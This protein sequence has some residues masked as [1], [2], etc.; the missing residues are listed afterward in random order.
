MPPILSAPLVSFALT[1]GLLLSV[2]W[3]ARHTTGALVAR[4]GWSA[5]PWTTGWLGVPVHELSHAAACLLTR[6]PIREVKLFAPDSTSGMMGCVTYEAGRGPIA[7][8]AAFVIGLAPLVGGGLVLSGL[9][10][11]LLHFGGQSLPH[12]PTACV[13]GRECQAL[14][15]NFSTISGWSA[16]ITPLGLAAKG[17]GQTLATAAAAVWGLGLWPRIALV[18]GSYLSA[19]VL[20]HLTPSSVDLMGTWK[21]ALLL[22]ILLVATVAGLQ[23]GGVTYAPVLAQVL[24]SLSA[25][26]APALL[27]AAGLLG[28]LR[29]F[30]AVLGRLLPGG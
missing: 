24:S 9:V 21:G 19:C 18:V 4:F 8:L 16:L 27:V 13:A 26:L 20:V 11:T 3:L 6:R 22:A 10:W 17:L 14:E 30:V 12:L 25:W 1:I 15:V 7:W 29:L 23:L 5:V 28:V 2:A